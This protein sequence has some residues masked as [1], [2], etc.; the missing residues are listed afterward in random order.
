MRAILMSWAVSMVV[1]LAGTPLLVRYFTE[2]GYGQ[3]IREDGPEAHLTKRGTPTMGGVAIIGAALVGYFSATLILGPRYS[4]GGL[5]AMATFVGMGLVG[6]LDDY[7]KLRRKRN[8]GLTKTAK[9]GGQGV[10]TAFFAYFSTYVAQSA[11]TLTFIGPLDLD[12]GAFFVIRTFVANDHDLL[13]A[14]TSCDTWKRHSRHS[15]SVI[16]AYRANKIA[17]RSFSSSHVPLAPNALSTRASSL[18]WAFSSAGSI[19]SGL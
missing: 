11:T 2:H 1:A 19:T 6:F 10:V 3:L 15:P 14:V 8:L 7:I 9:F 4:A 18:A 13:G 16:S 17:W 12:F 5:L